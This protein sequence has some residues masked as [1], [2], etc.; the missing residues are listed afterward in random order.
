[1]K[2]YRTKFGIEMII[3]LGLCFAIISLLCI[4]QGFWYM[5]FA[6]LLLVLLIAYLVFQIK[7][8]VTD[9]ELIIK[10]WINFDFESPISIEH[11][12]KIIEKR[13]WIKSPAGSMDK[14][15]IRYFSRGHENSVFISPKDKMG[16]ID[17]LRRINSRITVQ[18]A[19]HKTI[20]L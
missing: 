20:S 7:Y 4:L 9:K 8:I 17:E 12:S 16:F 6:I 3:M 10:C 14:L 2:T 1:M 18:L 13:N 11:I 19:E 5:S 15:E